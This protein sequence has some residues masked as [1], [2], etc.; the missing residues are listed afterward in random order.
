LHVLRLPKNYVLRMPLSQLI[1][2]KFFEG[3][4]ASPCS[5]NAIP[6]NYI[7]STWPRLVP[8]KL[9][10]PETKMINLGHQAL[11]PTPFSPAAITM[12]PQIILMQSN[13]SLTRPISFPCGPCSSKA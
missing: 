8:A 9:A 10:A 7:D 13:F 1:E 2:D 5:L 6:M 4:R 12:L 11:K 3:F